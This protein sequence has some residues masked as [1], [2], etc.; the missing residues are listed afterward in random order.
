M[1]EKM[2]PEHQPAPETQIAGTKCSCNC[3]CAC[4][5]VTGDLVS[6]Q[7]SQTLTISAG[8]S[9]GNENIHPGGG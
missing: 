2:N 7:P 4:A 9:S 8:D 6:S 3:A 5:C 1:I